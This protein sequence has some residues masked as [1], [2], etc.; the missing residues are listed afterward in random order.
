[1]AEMKTVDV[2]GGRRGRI[3]IPKGMKL[4]E[5]T[6]EILS[7][8]LTD[9]YVNFE[10][11]SGELDVVT[12]LSEIIYGIGGALIQYGHHEATMI[13]WDD[14]KKQSSVSENGHFE[15]SYILFDG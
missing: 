4:D 15:G 2:I 11:D 14:T 9:H 10:I 13:T 5:R 1:M 6:K 8:W 7:V 12:K 3:E